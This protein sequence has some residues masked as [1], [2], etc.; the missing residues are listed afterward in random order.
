MVV[1]PFPPTHLER[2]RKKDCFCAE[3]NFP[4]DKAFNLGLEGGRLGNEGKNLHVA[5]TFLLKI[6]YVN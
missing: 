2:Q 4:M 6:N 3:P 1:M 5:S